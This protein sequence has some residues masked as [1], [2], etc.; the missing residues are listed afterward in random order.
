MMFFIIYLNLLQVFIIMRNN[1]HVFRNAYKLLLSEFNNYF[2]E[3]KQVIALPACL[4][5][6]ESGHLGAMVNC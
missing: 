4:E 3:V 6:P 5:L 1:S 2:T